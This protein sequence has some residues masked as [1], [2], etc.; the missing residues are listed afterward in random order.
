MLFTV[1]LGTAV[2]AVLIAALIVAAL[3]V[4]PSLELRFGAELPQADIGEELGIP[5]ARQGSRRGGEPAPVHMP[6]TAASGS[7]KHATSATI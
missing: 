5:P 2:V 7:Q 6:P 3:I 4:A 1:W